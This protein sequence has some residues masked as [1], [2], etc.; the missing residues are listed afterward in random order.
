V[1]TSRQSRESLS[2]PA[3]AFR[4]LWD[5]FAAPRSLDAIRRAYLR[6]VPSLAWIEPSVVEIDEVLTLVGDPAA[7]R[8]RSAAFF[9]VPELPAICAEART[10][11]PVFAVQRRACSDADLRTLWCL[12]GSHWTRAG[13]YLPVAGLV[14]GIHLQDFQRTTKEICT[15]IFES[16]NV[17]GGFG[18]RARFADI[19]DDATL[20]RIREEL[21]PDVA[22][23][24]VSDTVELDQLD[25]R[26]MEAA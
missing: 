10:P 3:V 6:G 5:K 21:G 26:V 4:G 15:V 2:L 8:R 23:M 1:S 24:R 13:L 25:L 17:I 12:S 16:R 22:V 20:R 9:V 11:V 18:D 14:D 7:N 19:D